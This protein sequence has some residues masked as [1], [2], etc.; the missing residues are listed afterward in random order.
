M[1]FLS[2][3]V[4]F[5]R[6]VFED[7]VNAAKRAV[8]FFAHPVSVNV[9]PGVGADI[10]VDGLDDMYGFSVGAVRI[11]SRTGFGSIPSAIATQI[12]DEMLE[13]IQDALLP[14]RRTGELEESFHIRQ[15]G[16]MIEIYSTSKY[17]ATILGTSESWGKPPI[18]N[19]VGWIGTV[20][21]FDTG[22]AD[23]RLV[24]GAI[25]TSWDPNS[26]ATSETSDL[27]RLPPYGVKA[28]DY[29]KE[30]SSNVLPRFDGISHMIV[31]EV[32][33]GV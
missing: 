5:A 18:E 2:A 8:S 20:P 28:F 26:Y 33:H 23:P 29:V 3:A 1:S 12:A 16:D 31:R 19:L 24:A 7:S 25:F 10:S 17:A 15:N 14:I 22:G 21:K 13:G 6:S 32:T 27:Y 9:A 30:A 4:R 11:F